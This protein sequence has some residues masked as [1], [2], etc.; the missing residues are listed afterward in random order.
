MT[1]PHPREQLARQ[2]TRMQKVCCHA[3]HALAHKRGD[4]AEACG[5]LLGIVPPG[6]HFLETRRAGPSRHRAV[7]DDDGRLWL[8]CSRRT[9]KTWNLFTQALPA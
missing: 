1:A 8:K 6:W 4:L 5:E 9:C 3:R 2:P 7:L